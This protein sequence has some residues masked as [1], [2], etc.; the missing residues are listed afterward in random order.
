MLEL[1]EQAIV[2]SGVAWRP[3]PDVAC[4]CQPNVILV[5][6]NL[7]TYLRPQS[8]FRAPRCP[9]RPSSASRSNRRLRSC[10]TT[11]VVSTESWSGRICWHFRFI[12]PY[13][14]QNPNQ[15]DPTLRIVVILVSLIKIKNWFLSRSNHIKMALFLSVG[16]RTHPL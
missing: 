12:W 1:Y 8:R 11:R 7:S 9:S 15:P 6:Y 3:M 5:F 10:A 2:A 13:Q 14:N 4:T 16:W